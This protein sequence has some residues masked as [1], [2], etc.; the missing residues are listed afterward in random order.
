MH[1]IHRTTLQYLVSVNTPDYPEPTWKW[2]PD[3][4]QVVGIAPI[5]WKW[6]A[7]TERPIPMTA[8]EQAVVN[9]AIETARRDSEASQLTQVENI[10]RAIV[11]VVLDEINV[12]RSALLLTTRTE[13]QVRTAIRNKLGT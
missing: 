9:T 10:L 6:D 2:A 4:S 7:G 13:S 5:Y 3:M 12:L 11:L 1:V 8:G